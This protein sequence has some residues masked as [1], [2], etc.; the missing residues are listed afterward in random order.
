MCSALDPARCHVH[1][2]AL[3][4]VSVCLYLPP[5]TIFAQ[6]RTYGGRGRV[7]KRIKKACSVTQHFDHN[8]AHRLI[9]Y[10]T[11][12]PCTATL[13]QVYMCGSVRAWGFFLF[14]LCFVFFFCL[15]FSV[16]VFKSICCGEEAYVIRADCLFSRFCPECEIPNFY[17]QAQKTNRNKIAKLN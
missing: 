8:Y 2:V 9:S 5:A 15:L 13:F 12:A 7:T 11:H 10:S 14:F 4:H 17:A 3:S 6:G 1:Q 16:V